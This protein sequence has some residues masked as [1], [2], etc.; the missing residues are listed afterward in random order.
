MWLHP[1]DTEDAEESNRSGLRVA[2]TGP[3]SVSDNRNTQ[4][5]KSAPF[6]CPEEP[7]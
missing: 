1:K 4:D 6:K 7:S 2:T 5:N 3:P